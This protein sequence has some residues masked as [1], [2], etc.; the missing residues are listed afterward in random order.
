MLSQVLELDEFMITQERKD[1]RIDNYLSR[2]QRTGK[3]VICP[4][5]NTMRTGRENRNY[6][7][8]TCSIYRNW[9][10]SISA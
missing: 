9:S 10:E 6:A 4:D 7:V 2:G 3:A 5:E 8:I 1:G